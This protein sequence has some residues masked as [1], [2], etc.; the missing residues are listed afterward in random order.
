MTPLRMAVIGAGHLGK[1]HVRLLRSLPQA[2]LVGIVDPNT[3]ALQSVTDEFG[4]TGY[5]HYRDLV[6]RIDAAI[7]ATPTVLHHRVALDLLGQGVHTFI[8]KPLT[9]SVHLADALVRT[10]DK[11]N[12]VLQVGHVERFSPALSAAQP[13]LKNAHFFEATRTSGYTGRSTDI[14]VVLDLMIH[15]LDVVLTL[16]QQPI[17]EIEAIGS[18]IV[19][20]HEDLAHARLRFANGCVANFHASRVSTQPQRVL[21]AYTKEHVSVIDFSGLTASV[22]PFGEASSTPVWSTEDPPGLVHSLPTSPIQIPWQDLPTESNNPILEEQR[23]FLDCVLTG[24][25]P[26]VTGQQARDAVAICQQ[27]TG[28]IHAG[29]LRKVA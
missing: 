7:V 17:I 9:H 13:F 21:Q 24:K 20:P 2:E 6:G 18:T 8:E 23:N 3:A 12:V 19:G 26:R 4:V 22:L 11:Q 29:R 28:Q 14:G 15:D 27:I 25:A 16:V 5:S 1:I 10:A